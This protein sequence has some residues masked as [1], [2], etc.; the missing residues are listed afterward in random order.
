V[1]RSKLEIKF[2]GTIGLLLKA[3]EKGIIDNVSKLLN[4]MIGKGTWINPKL[5]D[6]VKLVARK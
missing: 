4:I 3:K 2:T 6:K 5:M 1:R